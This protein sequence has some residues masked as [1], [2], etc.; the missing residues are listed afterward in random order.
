MNGIGRD[1]LKA[2]PL[3]GFLAIDLHKQ[4]NGGLS[5]PFFSWVGIDVVHHFPDLFFCVALFRLIF[6]DYIPN[7]LM[8]ALTVAFLVAVH[9][10]TVKYPALDLPGFRVRFDLHRVGKL[11]PPVR[12]NHLEQHG[13]VGCPKPLAQLAEDLRHAR[14]RVSLPQEHQLQVT[15]GQEN[16]QEHLSPFM[17]H[18][19][20]HLAHQGVRILGHIGLVILICPSYMA[21]PVYPENRAAFLPL[22]SPYLTAQVDIPGIHQACIDIGVDSAV[23]DRQFIPVTFANGWKGL[24]LF[25]QRGNGIID[26]VQFLFCQGDSPAGLGECLLVLLLGIPG[27]IEHPA[28][29]AAEPALT[30]IADKGGL[31]IVR[32]ELLPVLRTAFLA[33]SAGSLALALSPET[34]R[35]AVR[36][37]GA[38]FVVDTVVATRSYNQTS[39]SFYFSSDS[40]PVFADVLCNLS[41]FEPFL[42]PCLNRQSV[43][44]GKVFLIHRYLQS[45]GR[46]G[47]TI[48]ENGIKRNHEVINATPW[49]PSRVILSATDDVAFNFSINPPHPPHPSNTFL[50]F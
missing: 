17:E 37:P 18:Y 14:R 22:R 13:K 11:T 48:P 1:F 26:P 50:F 19:A 44:I 21:F 35:T 5:V 45:E 9:G 29:P 39:V 30:G 36:N 8:V 15:A 25:Q 10:V 3:C 32:T 41:D 47:T 4:I 49:L 24:S 27:V 38:G 33:A 40:C 46:T 28:H 42:E 7:Q 23:R 2:K 12:H 43:I 16:R 6:R 20:V 34:A 31:L